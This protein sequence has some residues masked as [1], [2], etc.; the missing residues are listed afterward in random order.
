[1]HTKLTL[2]LDEELIKSAK[3]YA[4][5]TGR[6]VSQIV[7]AY[8][9]RLRRSTSENVGESALVSSLKGSLRG[10]DVQESDYHRHLEDRHL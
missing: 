10:A 5:E 8:F 9:S 7:A 3:L 4:S 6:S 2:R 1:M